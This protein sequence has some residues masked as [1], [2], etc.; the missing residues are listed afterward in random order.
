MEIDVKKR[1]WEV[2][3]LRGLAIITMI[4]YHFLFDITFFGVYPFEVNSGFLWYFA[5]AT[6]FTFIFLMG[7][8]LTSE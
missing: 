6:A 2:D 1:F 8:S 5:R 7:V 4:T 3:S